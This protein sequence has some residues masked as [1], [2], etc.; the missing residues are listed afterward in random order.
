MVVT[1]QVKFVIKAL[2]LLCFLQVSQPAA[3]QM[4]MRANLMIVDNNGTTLMDANMTNYAANYSNLV[5]GNDIWKMSNFSENFGILRQTANLVIERRNLI[6]GT[7]TTYFRMWNMRQLHYR[8]QVIA[9]NLHQSN[10]IGFVRDNYLNQDTPINLNDTSYVDFYVTGAAGSYAHNRFSL[11][12]ISMSSAALPV[13]FTGI[14]AMRKGNNV[15]VNWDAQNEISLSK[16]VVERS[17]NGTQFTEIATV[18]ASNEAGK[19]TYQSRDVVYGEADLYYRI[20]AVS[21]GGK[22]QYSPVAHVSDGSSDAAQ[23]SIFPNPVTSKQFQIKLNAPGEKT[24]QLS[25]IHSGGKVEN[26]SPINK[27][28][29]SIVAMVNLPAALAPGLYQ[30]KIA[31]PGEQPLIKTI[32]VL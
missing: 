22:Q 19:R 28:S 8:I 11:I 10:L 31:A 13:T 21:V 26:L 2:I 25:L 3:A 17:Y 20:K 4:R 18:G 30:L 5:D 24:Y 27:K 32:V 23:L 15:Q 16:Y 14:R 9:E 29:G 12:Y 1:T 6:N 7:D